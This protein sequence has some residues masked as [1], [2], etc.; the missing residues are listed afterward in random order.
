EQVE[1]F[2]TALHV[3]GT[4]RARLEAAL[5][6]EGVTGQP[7][8]TSLEDVFIRLMELSEDNMR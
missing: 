5:A 4:D 3:T 7:A 8:E 6:A 2:G 1:P